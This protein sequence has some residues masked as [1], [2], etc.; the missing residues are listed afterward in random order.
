MV[1][2]NG[3]LFKAG[4]NEEVS[5]LDAEQ[6]EINT[7]ITSSALRTDGAIQD[8]TCRIDDGSAQ[9]SPG[10]SNACLQ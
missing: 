9:P 8:G 5:L 2:G 10:A 1:S 6:A 7:L 4:K 3:T